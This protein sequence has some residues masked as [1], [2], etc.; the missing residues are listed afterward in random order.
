MPR[1]NQTGEF[2]TFVGGL[3]TEASP[4]TFPENA[5]IDEANFILN[6]DGSRRRR[7]G[8]D[9]E[10]GLTPFPV[11]YT[12]SPIGD[13]A[14]SAFEW[15]DV[16]GIPSKSF[17]ACQV[18][19]KVY[20][21][22][23]AD[24]TLKSTSYIKTTITI[25]TG[26]TDHK[27][28]S[29]AS[30]DGRLVIASGADTVKVVSYDNATGLFSSLDVAIKTRDLFGVADPFTIGGIEEDLLSPEFI[31]YRPVSVLSEDNHIYN[32]RNQGWAVPRAEWAA[33]T[34]D[35]EDP[36]TAFE[37]P[38]ATN[39]GLPSNADT[40]I[41]SIY[42]NTAVT[43]KNTERFNADSAVKQ[44][45]ARARA[46][47]G[48]FVIDL[49]S[50][51]ASRTAVNTTST[52]ITNGLY[53]NANP[54]SSPTY[55]TFRTPTLS[56]PV[57]KSTGGVSVVGEFAG[58]LW[59]GGFT[60]EVESGDSQSPK[61]ASYVFYSQ[62]VQH[63]DQVAYCYQEGDPTD[64]VA[65]DILDTDGGFIR[66]SGAYNIQK[67]VNI[68]TSLL[69]F[70]ENG[71]WAI[72]GSDNGTFTANNQGV[73]KLTEHG[74]VSPQTVVVIDGTIMYWSDDAIY[75]LT[76]NQSGVLVAKDISINITSLYQGI[77]DEARAEC[78]GIY[79]NYE[80]KVRWLYNNTE[81]NLQTTE[82][83]FDITLAAFTKSVI[84][85]LTGA[86]IPIL[87]SPVQVS[88]FNTSLVDLTVLSGTDSVL[89][90]TDTVV[91]EA[92]LA[93]GG[94]RA[95]AYITLINAVDINNTTLTFS[96]YS[97]TDFLDWKTAD[98]VGVDAAA[99]ALTGYIGTGD[100]QRFK[101]VPYIYF[102]FTRTED[103]FT[104]NGDDLLPTN[105]SSCLVQSQWDWSNS[106]S[107]GKWGAQ[108]QAYRYKRRYTPSDVTDTYDY[109]TT[110]IVSKSKLRGR[111]RV[112]S[113][114]I[115]SE[116]G[117]NMELLGWSINISSN[118]NI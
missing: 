22:D 97:D 56:L 17:I 69:V 6:R 117:K 89:S 26:C 42:P 47:S 40:P 53:S 21:M 87:S 101:Q 73:D 18:H 66:L 96:T 7:L 112:V 113:L 14:V 104:D 35:K 24:D 45:P 19:D 30:V 80:K 50:R 10:S 86:T 49:L 116:A 71:V 31:A 109:G 38:T 5:S 16:A 20:L 59:Y 41:R 61:L 27:K 37:D 105:E 57:D 93:T 103:G 48:H 33:G 68:G 4:L 63:E 81:G 36:I 34:P 115:N 95:T 1:S 60:S 43:D 2:N 54:T 94:Y 110:T 67:M 11:T 65:P 8:M 13:I 55:V 23:R 58:R 74:T 32:L 9:Y 85:N 12:I 15:V 29:F 78:Q 111:G 25:C 62:L 99:Y 100:Y 64:L 28:A 84:T 76:P 107:Y 70:A 82:L 83:T 98:T 77:V 88:P 114:L 75:H 44:E 118:N 106:A 39:R 102:H 46:A 79:D 92:S 52:H 90:D 91:S 3:V 72:G 51:G 108:F